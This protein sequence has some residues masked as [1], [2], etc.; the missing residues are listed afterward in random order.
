MQIK[1][2]TDSFLGFHLVKKKK[3]SLTAAF[4]SGRIT[5]SSG[6]NKLERFPSAADSLG[7]GTKSA[8]GRV[9]EL[10]AF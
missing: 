8:I 6:D 4:S 7:H 9:C 2:Y 3:T 10:F 1:C 5:S